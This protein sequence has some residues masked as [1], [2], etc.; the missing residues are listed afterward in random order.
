MSASLS[1]SHRIDDNLSIGDSHRLVDRLG[2]L[3][4]AKHEQG[5]VGAG[6]AEASLQVSAERRPVIAGRR[7]VGQSRR[8]DDGPVQS[9]VPY[10]VLHLGAVVLAPSYTEV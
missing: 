1:V 8:P 6:N 9:A 10:H 4:R 7:A 3:Q 2:Q 5:D